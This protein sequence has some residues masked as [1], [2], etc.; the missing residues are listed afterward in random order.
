MKWSDLVKWLKGCVRPVF[1][2]FLT[3]YFNY[4]DRRIGNTLLSPIIKSKYEHLGS[5]KVWST[6]YRVLRRIFN[7]FRLADNDVFVDVGCGLGR[8]LS[9]L[10]I[11]GVKCRLIGI[12]LDEQAANITKSRLSEFKQVEILNKNVMDCL[13]ED[14]TVFYLFNPFDAARLA[15]F[16]NKIEE[17]MRHNVHVIYLFDL[18]REILLNRN[19]WSVVSEQTVRRWA[20]NDAHYTIFLYEPGAA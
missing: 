1:L 8:V 19:K 6:D 10:L 2:Y 18:H 3:K 4:M 5:N 20:C 12:E 16:A 17:V 13:P 7:D 15:M 14:A 9:Y 11:R